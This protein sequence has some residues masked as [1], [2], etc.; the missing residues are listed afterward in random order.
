MRVNLRPAEEADVPE[1]SALAKRTWADAFG[2]SVSTEDLAAELENTRSEEYFRAALAADTIL[3]AE[4]D[5][6]LVGYVQF[7]DVTIPEVEVRPG[8]QGLRRV[9]VETD[10]HGRGIGRALMNA[11]LA[12]PR[13]AAARRIYLA[14]W[15]KNA[16]AI[17]LYESLGFR[18][19]GTTRFTI[20]SGE[21]A[22][23][24]VMLLERTA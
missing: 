24:L 16:N 21:V 10:R 1:L 19:V 11:A 13:L 9:Y 6:D 18:T 23:D 8:D 15:E 14:V 2:S 17:G 7:G 5:G 20:G 4:L 3:V 12:H 22:E